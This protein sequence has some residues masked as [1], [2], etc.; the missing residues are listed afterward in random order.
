MPSLP[1][2][3]TVA[4][5]LVRSVVAP[6][7]FGLLAVYAYG[8]AKYRRN[9]RVAYDFVEVLTP[10]T[11]GFSRLLTTLSGSSAA[12]GNRVHGSDHAPLVRRHRPRQRSCVIRCGRGVE[13]V[14]VGCALRAPVS[15]V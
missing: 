3:R 6:A 11:D 15:L 1:P 9:A 8:T 4:G 2:L 10:G 12:A 13:L 7:V 14:D 5:G